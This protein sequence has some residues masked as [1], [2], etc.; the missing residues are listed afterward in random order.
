MHSFVLTIPIDGAATTI[1]VVYPSHENDDDQLATGL[2]QLTEVFNRR[3]VPSRLLFVCPGPTASRVAAAFKSQS[4]IFKHRLRSISHIAIAPYDH[5]GRLL[6]QQIEYLTPPEAAW[7][8]DDA[9]LH[10]VAREGVAV[11]FE[12]T[13]T[14]LRAP[15]GYAF[16]KPSGREEDIFVRAGNMLRQ[17]GAIAIF[18]HLLLRHLPAACSVLYIDSFTILSFA[19]GLQSLTAHFDRSGHAMPAL[20]IESIHSYDISKSVWLPVDANYLVLIS[21][22]TSGGLA[23]MLVD[24]HQ[25]DRNRI[26]HL[27][28]VGAPEAAFKNSCVYFHAR[29]QASGKLSP[30]NQVNASI[31]IR[32]EEF[33]VSQGPPRPVRITKAHIDER[34][35]NQLHKPFYG[36]A[37]RFEQSASSNINRSY[38][39]FSIATDQGSPD[40]GLRKWVRKFLIHD[41]PASV[42]TLLYVDDPMAKQ[43]ADWTTRHL[44]SHVVAKPL[45]Q[46]DP[47]TEG[48]SAT[49]TV[50]VI[51]YD[52]PGLEDLTRAAIELRRIPDINR[53]FVVC[54]GFPAS[55]VDYERRRSDL[56]MAPNGRRYGWTEFLV[57]PV[58][59]TALHDSLVSYRQLLAAKNVQPHA[60]E[61]GDTLLAS[62]LQQGSSRHICG[63]TLF[64]PRTSGAPLE[65]RQRSVFLPR[66]SADGV[67]Q[68]AVYAMVS[69]AFQAAREPRSARIQPMTGF[70]D[71]PFVRSVLDP[72]MFARYSDGILQ[73]SLLRA[74]QRSELD[75][76]ASDYL[77]QQFASTCATIILNHENPVGDAAL[78]FLYAL[79][80]NK[81]SLRKVDR[82]RLDDDIASNPILRA[83]YDLCCSDDPVAVHFGA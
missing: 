42:R 54:Y 80:T 57:L 74:A 79:A 76:S 45:N 26:V 24:E 19:M 41:L 72:S 68:I 50:A 73:A 64:L 29:S 23:K 13:E 38:S 70:D 18:N 62:L 71:N 12:D 75:Y 1:Q 37:L 27:L 66:S 82:Q 39:P 67:S 33:L 5:Q 47:S 30:V 21:A 36:Q 32:T 34:A 81:V 8:F 53:H 7:D 48:S 56:Q 43:V 55:R 69:A 31:E 65:L 3:L 25:A 51:A 4:Q 22:S 14:I 44:G 83:F 2:D 52:D 46:L 78:E 63:S 59:P 77:S 20:A 40:K 15:H 6:L 58:G 61:L 60:A 11:L 28:G 10:T 9:F 35:A 49:N 17:P 16:R